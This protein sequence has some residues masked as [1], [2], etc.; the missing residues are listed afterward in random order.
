MH[1]PSCWKNF[2]FFEVNMWREQRRILNKSSTKSQTFWSEPCEICQWVT[3]VAWGETSGYVGGA[4]AVKRRCEG[5]PSV[6]GSGP[7][8]NHDQNRTKLVHGVPWCAAVMD[9]ALDF[10]S[11][12]SNLKH[13]ANGH[14]QFKERLGRLGLIPHDSAWFRTIGTFLVAGVKSRADRARPRNISVYLCDILRFGLLCFSSVQFCGQRLCWRHPVT[15]FTDKEL[16]E[17]YS[18]FSPV[19]RARV[20]GVVESVELDGWKWIL[21]ARSIKTCTELNRILFR[22][23][24]RQIVDG[25]NALACVVFLMLQ[26]C[27]HHPLRR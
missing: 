17:R 11:I 24:I 23:W 5:W 4:A 7:W 1:W 12:Q 19:G 3:V 20:G 18:R 10:R 15:T 8:P 27:C 2:V 6:V 21:K 13:H 25:S 9:M 16:S 14:S 26:D 22:P